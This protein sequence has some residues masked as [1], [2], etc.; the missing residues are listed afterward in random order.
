MSLRNSKQSGEAGIGSQKSQESSQCSLWI[1]LKNIF[2][3]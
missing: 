3:L 1:P 2:W